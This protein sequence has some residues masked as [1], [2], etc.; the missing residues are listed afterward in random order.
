M[1]DHQQ[2]IA[3]LLERYVNKSC[4]R[5]EL[6]EL[7]AAIGKGDD[8][9][10]LE[11]FL[12][13]SWHADLAAPDID[14]E[15]VYQQIRPVQQ[16]RRAVITLKRV[17][18]AA[19]FVL[20]AG[21]TYW[22]AARRQA[23]PK[24]ALA[25]QA[26]PASIAPGTNRAVLTLAD[27]SVVTLDS[28]GKQVIRQGGIAIQQQNGQ[29]S[30]GSQP[31]DGTVHYNKLTTPRGGQFRVVLPDGTKVWLNSA[32]ML[33]YP[34]AFTG[35]ERVVELEGQGYFEVAANAQQPFKVK[36]HSMEVQ[37][38][39][40]DFDIMAYRDEASINTTLLA[41]SVQVKEGSNEQILRPGQQAVMNNED[42]QLTVRIADIKKVT[43]WKNGLF[44]FNNMALPAILREVARWYDV[45]IVYMASPGTEL[46][47]GGIGRNL[48]L[49]DILAL[50]EGNGYNHFRVEGRKVIV[51]P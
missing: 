48:Q 28:T 32:S 1:P 27:G 24:P 34:T 14:Y 4:S 35:R 3:Y 33:R 46:Y 21:A 44:V 7:F 10:A 31:A 25:E 49:A 20:V 45:D 9:E 30:Y 2:R 51:L 13:E 22:L 8:P 16:P 47:G 12:E 43:A 6:D 29:L 36:V 41:G 42:H 11:R 39:G 18:V 17:A 37:V 15:Q 19:A 26:L 50:L 23:V 5:E 38:L 40:T